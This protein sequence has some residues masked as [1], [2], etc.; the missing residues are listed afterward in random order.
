MDKIPLRE[1]PFYISKL[2]LYISADTGNYYIADSLNVPTICLMGPC[3]SS[4]Q[5]GVF[6][7]LIINSDLKPVSSVFKTARNIDASKFFMINEK[8]E[9]KILEFIQALY[10]KFMHHLKYKNL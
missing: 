8:D 4:E 1:L 3:F 7:S 6:N 9:A 10:E 5:R 2:N